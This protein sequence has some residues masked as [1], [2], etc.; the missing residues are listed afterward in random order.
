MTLQQRKKLLLNVVLV[1]S[2]TLKV[3]RHRDQQKGGSTRRAST[4]DDHGMP[5]K[6]LFMFLMFLF[7]LVETGG[8]EGTLS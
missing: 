2:T 5:S 6:W 1:D 3:H 4:V 7:T 8:K